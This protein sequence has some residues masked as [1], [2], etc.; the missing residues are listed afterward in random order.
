MLKIFTLILFSASLVFSQSSLIK[1]NLKTDDG[2]I[3]NLTFGVHQNATYS[4]DTNLGEVDLPSTPK[5]PNDYGID[6]LAVF[7][8]SVYNIDRWSRL[9]LI[10]IPDSQIMHKHDFRIWLEGGKKFTITW[11]IVGD[12]IDSAF[13]KDEVNGSFINIDLFND[14]EYYWNNEN[15]TTLNLDLIVWYN[16]SSNSVKLINNHFKIYPNPTRENIFIDKNFEKGEIYSINGKKIK[17]FSSKNVN[18]SEFKTGTYFIR[19]YQGK[20]VQIGKFIIE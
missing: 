15:V 10:P 4:L 12:N 19:L 18:I 5:S 1:L 16:G 17:D 7:I 8:D 13:I 14:D 20:N 2:F 9:D 11:E 3:A 6:A